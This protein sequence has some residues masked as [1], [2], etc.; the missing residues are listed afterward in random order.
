MS[1]RWVFEYEDD[2]GEVTEYEVRTMK[3]VCPRCRGK[4]SYVNPSIDNGGITEDSELHDDPD[5]REDYFRG[6]YDV[7]C[8]LCKGANVIDD[9]DWEDAM[10][11]HHGENVYGKFEE[12]QEREWG[13]RRESLAERRFE[14]HDI[15]LDIDDGNERGY[16]GLNNS[17]IREIKEVTYEDEPR[18][19]W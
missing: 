6:V 14:T 1:Q 11:R 9:V 18:N 2:E 16:Y 7:E 3:V 4:G 19:E 15:N 17:C 13:Y 12:M 8:R 10:S 5:F